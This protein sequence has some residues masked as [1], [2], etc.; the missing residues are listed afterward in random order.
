MPKRL[1]LT[2]KTED[3]SKHLIAGEVKEA[4]MGGEEGEGGEG[5]ELPQTEE[6]AD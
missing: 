6:Q 1:Q 3:D 2:S 4:D 5:D